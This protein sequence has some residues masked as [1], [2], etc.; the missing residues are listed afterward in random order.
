MT[1]NLESIICLFVCFF[2]LRLF[3]WSPLLPGEAGF[4]LHSTVA[5]FPP[6]VY[7]S[8]LHLKLLHFYISFCTSCKGHSW[9]IG[10]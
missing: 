7:V 9:F 2:F 4:I 5:A 10:L 1:E 6:T 3:V 8:F